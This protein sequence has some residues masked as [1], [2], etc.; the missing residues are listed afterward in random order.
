MP[1]VNGEMLALDLGANVDC[2]S[3]NLIDFSVMGVVFAQQVLGKPFPKFSF[4]NVGEEENKGKI[5]IHEAASEIQ[6][7]YFSKFY[8]GYIEGNNLITG[9]I[10]VVVCDGL[11]ET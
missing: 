10:D 5:V 7:G 1:T 6:K 8:N 11:A 4:L 9:E 2:T 3:Q